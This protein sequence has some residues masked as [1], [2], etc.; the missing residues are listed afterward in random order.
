M[1]AKLRGGCLCGTVRY[2]LSAGPQAVTHCHCSM[3]RK[4]HGAAF[5]T[6]GSVRRTEHAFTQGGDVLRSFRATPQVTRTFCSLCG[7]PLLWHIA[8]KYEDWLS[9]PLGTLD[10]LFVPTYQKHIHVGSKA[11][12][13]EI[14]DGWPQHAEW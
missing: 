9:I 4:H 2:E 6:H 13:F 12:W 11:S 1:D 14:T 8:G 7:S 10:T 3:C 5:A